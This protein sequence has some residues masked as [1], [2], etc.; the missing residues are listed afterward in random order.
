MD[1][2]GEFDMGNIPKSGL[3]GGNEAH[4]IP[5]GTFKHQEDLK[6]Y[7]QLPDY[8]EFQGYYL[9]TDAEI[10]R[11]AEKIYGVKSSLHTG[12]PFTFLK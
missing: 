9:R 5:A 1:L 12:P 10:G 11:I 8:D 2:S 3:E 7:G 4:T 6:M